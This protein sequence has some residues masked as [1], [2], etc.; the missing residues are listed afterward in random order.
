MD[1]NQL[2]II[3]GV[4]V[5]LLAVIGLAVAFMR[6][7]RR[8]R[9]ERLRSE[10]G[11]EY[12]RTV[13]DVGRGRAEKDLVDRQRRAADLDIRPLARDDARTFM[14]TWD[15]AQARF[16]EAP[17]DAVARATQL[18]GEVLHSRG[19]PLGDFERRA[20][21]ISVQYPRAAVHYREAHAI[22]GR[23]QREEASTEDL[24]QVMVHYRAILTDL[25]EVGGQP[26]EVEEVAAARAS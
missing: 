1:T 16:V 5:A 19:Y 13:D 8:K 10:F 7:R 21:D 25:V 24:R 4:A 15:A 3:A 17:A 12:T 18:I 2:L 6:M 9:S 22:A 11:E 26:H 23:N 14:E 20:G